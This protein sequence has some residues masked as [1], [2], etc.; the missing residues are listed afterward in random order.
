MI[1]NQV[2]NEVKN[3][4]INTYKPEAIYLFGSYA[5]GKPNEDSDLDLLI[6]INETKLPPHKRPVAGYLALYEIDGPPTDIL[7]YTKSE[8]NTL[9]KKTYNLSYKIKTKGKLIYARA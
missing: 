5:W 8:F 6:V 2:I 7:V 4:L 9:I 1:S 3:R